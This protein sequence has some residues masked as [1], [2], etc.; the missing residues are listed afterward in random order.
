MGKKPNHLLDGIETKWRMY[1]DALYHKRVAMTVQM[2]GDAATVA[3]NEV[4]HMGPGRAEQFCKAYQEALDG[5]S[6]LL[7]A[8]QKDDAD[9][10]YTREKVDQRLKAICGE[11]FSPREERYGG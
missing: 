1:Y 10:A 11:H 8:D 7:L 3:A 5:M 4:F 6:T 9:Y 2:C